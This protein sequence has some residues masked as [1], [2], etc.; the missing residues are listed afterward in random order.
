MSYA[1]KYKASFEDIDGNDIE[2]YIQKE[3]YSGSIENLIA[4]ADP[5]TIEWPSVRGNIFNPVRGAVARLTVWADTNNKFSEFFDAYDKEYKIV[6]DINS[7]TYWSGFVMIGEHQEQ[8][9]GA[10]YKVTFT[11]QDLGML[12]DIEFDNGNGADDTILDVIQYCLSETG[13]SL[14]VK[15]RVNIYEDSINSTSSDSVL[16]QI[17]VHQSANFDDDWTPISCYEVLQEELK[18]FNAFLMQENNY[19]NICR[20]PDMRLEHNYRVFTSAGA[21]GAYD[22]EDCTVDL[23]DYSILHRPG[24]LLA[25]PSWKNLNL[26]QYQKPQNLIQNGKMSNTDVTVS[27]LWTIG[28]IGADVAYVRNAYLPT[29][30]G[31]SNVLQ[32]SNTSVTQQYITQKKTYSVKS[33]DYLTFTY[34]INIYSAFYI[35]SSVPVQIKCVVGATTYYLKH[36]DGS[37]STNS[38]DARI[39]CSEYTLTEGT[40]NADGFPGDGT[41]SIVLYEADWGS[42]GSNSAI[43]N[44]VNLELYIRG[45]DGI[46]GTDYSESIS[47]SNL[48][49]PSEIALNR[50]DASN[51]DYFDVLAGCYQTTGGAATDTWQ[52]ILG[53]DE[54]TIA[55]LCANCYKAQYTKPAMRLQATIRGLDAYLKVLTDLNDNKFLPTSVTYHVAGAQWQGEWIEIKY[56]LGDNL[57]DG[58]SNGYLTTPNYDTFSQP[59]TDT[60]Y[61]VKAQTSTAAGATIENLDVTSGLRYRATAIVT[62]LGGNVDFPTITIAGTD[63]LLSDGETTWEFISNTTSSTHDGEIVSL[64]AHVN[65]LFIQLSLQQITGI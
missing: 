18:P 3:G 46:E 49:N 9:S 61:L 48:L 44:Y 47:T 31:Q 36:S 37:W 54:D 51:A 8:F 35:G 19:W 55:Q 17:N 64:T 39:S 27:D 28:T 57:V 14:S 41:L 16:K 20:V 43:T 42:P 7:S 4:A 65:Q 53:S 12:Q 6:I 56:G 21:A 22:T 33:G 5:L 11:A 24:I 29:N 62:A 63:Q 60:V 1:S 58:F 15:E 23:S 2:V 32:F 34:S 26:F 30:S 52:S 59:Q 38:T 45:E 50:G 40:V 25:A 10:P 13:L